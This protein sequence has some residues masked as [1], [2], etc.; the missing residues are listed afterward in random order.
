VLY[1]NTSYDVRPNICHSVVTYSVS[2]VAIL[3][4]ILALPATY[5]FCLQ[6]KDNDIDLWKAILTLMMNSTKKGWVLLINP[7]P[8]MEQ[9]NSNSLALITR[10]YCCSCAYFLLSTACKIIKLKANM[11]RLYSTFKNNFVDKHITTSRFKHYTAGQMKDFIGK[12]LFQ[13]YWHRCTQ[14]KTQEG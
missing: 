6:N 9:E 4:L 1:S 13:K 7:K 2:A 14:N 3:C 11:I 12:F 5:F 8:G 10:K